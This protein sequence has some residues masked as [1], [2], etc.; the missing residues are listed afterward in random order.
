MYFFKTL[1]RDNLLSNKND[2]YNVCDSI[3]S[4]LIGLFYSL[5]QMSD[6]VEKCVSSYMYL[7]QS[8]LKLLSTATDGYNN[9]HFSLFFELTQDVCQ[10]MTLNFLSWK[11]HFKLDKY[12]G[13]QKNIVITIHMKSTTSSNHTPQK[14]TLKLQNSHWPSVAWKEKL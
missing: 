5:S 12:T 14:T 11:F 6:S 9:N 3:T 2:K 13:C 7:F 8:L 10:M 4:W 1:T